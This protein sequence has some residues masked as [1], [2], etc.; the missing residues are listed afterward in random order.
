MRRLWQIL[1]WLLGVL[2]V[3]AI[4]LPNFIKV[5]YG[6]TQFG[7]AVKRFEVLPA[8]PVHPGD[9][10]I[11]N[12][13][14]A[15]SP[16]PNLAEVRVGQEPQPFTLANDGVPPDADAHDYIWSARGMLIRPPGEYSVCVVLRRGKEELIWLAPP[17]TVLPYEQPTAPTTPPEPEP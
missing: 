6:P 15:S 7:S 17:L 4:L 16:D 10:L 1:A 12:V 9:E 2:A 3:G 13:V 8:G 14:I 5:K 11:F